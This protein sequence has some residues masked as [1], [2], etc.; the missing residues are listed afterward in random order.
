MLRHWLGR[1]KAPPLH[2]RA[3]AAPLRVLHVGKFYPPYRG[4]MESFLADLIEQQRASGIDAY[5]V[6]HGDPLPDD[7]P[8]LIRV[9]VQITLVFAPIAL[10]FPLA[11]HRAIAAFKP[12]VLHL[13]MPNNAAFWALLMPA[14]RRVAWVTHWHSDVLISKW[15]SLLQL[16]YQVYKPFETK[17]LRQSDAILATSPPYMAASIPLQR[18][19]FK[20]LAIPLGL[21]PLGPAALEQAQ[22]PPAALWGDVRLRVLSVGR[23]TYYKG[24]DTLVSAVA[25]FA[26]VQLLIAGEGEQRKELEALIARERAQQGCANVQLLG[27]VSEAQKHA[28]FNSCDIFA[29]ASRERT[30]AFGLVLI[31]AMQH[32]KPCMASD[33]DGSGMSWV[34]GQSG[35]GQCYA[36]DQVQ[37]WKE[38]IR[39]ALAAKAQLAER[40]LVAQQAADAYFSI[41]Q[42]E[43]RIA[44]VYDSLRPA[45]EPAPV[46]PPVAAPARPLQVAVVQQAGQWPALAQW[47]AAHPERLLLCVDASGQ[48]LAAAR[49]APDGLATVSLADLRWPEVIELIQRLAEEQGLSDL[50]ICAAA[51]LWGQTGGTAAPQPEPGLWQRWLARRGVR[52]L[53]LGQGALVL[54]GAELAAW[55]GARHATL[56]KHLF[57]RTGAASQA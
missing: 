23:L 28:L 33:L 52:H 35:S 39:Q 11:L 36:P 21:K 53:Q 9:P 56:G 5:A 49:P 17:L 40:G 26:D 4:G 54:R 42:C 2:A 16:C 3:A 50:S 6:V 8:W 41:G 18:W 25:G 27:Q 10:G 7:P 20:T 19:L 45:A 55:V 51:D 15:D 38:A 47:Q 34:V 46:L 43:R 30:E 57:M 1:P 29:L 37:A 31:E 32:G 14:A 44:E 22:T 48:S 12:D 13:H 24:F